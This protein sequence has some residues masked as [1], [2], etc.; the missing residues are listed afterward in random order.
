VESS[1][2]TTLRQLEHRLEEDP[3]VAEAVLTVSEPDEP[4]APAADGTA[5]E[6]EE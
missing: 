1:I 2:A 6:G 4:G 3:F 5:D